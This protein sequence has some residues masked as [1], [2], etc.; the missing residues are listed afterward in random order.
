M[1]IGYSDSTHFSDHFSY[2]NYFNPSYGLKDMIFQN[3]NHFL[4][5][6]KLFNLEL[7]KIVNDDVNMTSAVKPSGPG[8]T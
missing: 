5:L 4:E 1:W 8:Q 3:F 7:S 2:I 6:F